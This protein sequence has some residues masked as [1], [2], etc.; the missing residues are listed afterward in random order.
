MLA[1]G[2][3]DRLVGVSDVC[4]APG[5][6]VVVRASPVGHLL[7]ADALR[8][9]RPDILLA[10]SLCE[11][12]AA[13]PAHAREAERILGYAPRLVDLSPARLEDALDG[14]LAV[15][16][17]AGEPERG[18]RLRAALRDRLARVQRAPPLRVALLEWTDP[19]MRAGHWLPDVVEAAGAREVLGEPGGKSRRCSWEDVIA[20]RPDVV[21]V[22]PC[23]RSLDEARAEAKLAAGRTGLPTMA[24]D[25]TI[26]SCSGPR[27]VDAV[28]TLAD[29]LRSARRQ[30]RPRRA[31]GRG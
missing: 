29:D 20:A 8:A 17:A 31:R 4:R 15:A 26:L 12:C 27:L 30:E 25:G 10:Q 9:A 22:A 2:L 28:E 3:G 5:A 1:L 7:D 14:A 21:L 18:E 16:E 11:V 23:G 13:T 19:P 24:F 6:P